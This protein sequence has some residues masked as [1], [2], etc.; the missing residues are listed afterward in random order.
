MAGKENEQKSG[1]EIWGRRAVYGGIVAGVIGIIASPEL[2]LAG[3]G[4]A[5]AGVIFESSGNKKA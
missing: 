4:L 1:R 2:V 3:V 5:A